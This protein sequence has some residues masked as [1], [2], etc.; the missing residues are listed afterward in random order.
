MAAYPY[1]HFWEGGKKDRML[2]MLL[3]RISKWNTLLFGGLKKHWHFYRINFHIAWHIAV[4]KKWRGNK[5]T[6]LRHF[7]IKISYCTLMIFQN[8]LCF[9]PCRGMKTHSMKTQHLPGSRAAVSCPA[10]VS[11]KPCR[12]SLGWPPQTATC[13]SWCGFE[14]WSTFII[15]GRVCHILLDSNYIFQ[16]RLSARVPNDDQQALFNHLLWFQPWLV[17]NVLLKPIARTTLSGYVT[18]L[19]SGRGRFE[20]RTGNYHKQWRQ[21]FERSATVEI[22]CNTTCFYEYS[23]CTSF[24]P[25]SAG[26][27]QL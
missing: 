22:L 3:L 7:V 21:K 10:P 14:W 24:V 13:F 25:T 12:I 5:P 9:P 2:E 1:F 19:A 23:D 27:E 8:L 4:W 17:I 26:I 11:A 18:S 20:R 15:F 6:D 16:G